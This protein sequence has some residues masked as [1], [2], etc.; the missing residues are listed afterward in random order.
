M[1]NRTND[2]FRRGRLRL[3]ESYRW[4]AAGLKSPLPR[5]RIYYVTLEDGASPECR[6]YLFCRRLAHG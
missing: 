4:A 6:S 1:K 5:T 3:S 2:R